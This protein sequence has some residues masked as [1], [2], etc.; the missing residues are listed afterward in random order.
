VTADFDSVRDLCESRLRDARAGDALPE[1]AALLE[2]VI[3]SVPRLASLP[4]P[5]AVTTL[6][7]DE[8]C[9]IASADDRA[10]SRCRFGSSRF[11]RLMRIATL[12]RFPAGQFEWEVS[13]ISR[14]ECLRVGP[15]ALPRLAAFI[16]FRM[17]GFGP[18]FFSHLNPRR[19][20]RSLSELEA[21]KSYY[22]MAGALARQPHV[23]G[24]AACSW[25]RSPATQRV[26]PHLSWISRVFV[27]NGGLVVESGRDDPESG[28]L[29]RSET[30]RS[31]YEAGRYTPTRGLAIWPRAAMLAWA[32]AHPELAGPPSMASQRMAE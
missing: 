31:L 11:E 32:A 30:R 19:P 18:V 27:E 16:A 28:A 1:R 13:G 15:R 20:H 4:V 8:F 25:F 23:L 5:Q 12:S 26:S 10:L 3:A 21:N 2:A 24:F 17:R 29:Y 22:L 7:L 6:I 9:F 14:A